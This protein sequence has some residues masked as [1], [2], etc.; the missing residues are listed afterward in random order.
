MQRRS[1]GSPIA[2]VV[3]PLLFE[4]DYAARFDHVVAIGCSSATQRSRLGNR[5]WSGDHVKARLEAQMPMEE[6][7][8][9]SDAVIWNEGDLVCFEDQWRLLLDRWGC[10]PG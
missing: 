7:M 9:R 5:G 2:F 4:K 10:L 3:I 1:S 8:R 6:K